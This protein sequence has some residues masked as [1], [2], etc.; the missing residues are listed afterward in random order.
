MT[1]VEALKELA[2]KIKGVAPDTLTEETISEVIKVISDNYS[3]NKEAHEALVA[4]VEK[5]LYKPTSNGTDGQVLKTLGNGQ[6]EW[7]N[8][9][10]SEKIEK[11]TTT[12]NLGNAPEAWAKA[13][14][15]KIRER[16]NVISGKIDELITAVTTAGLMKS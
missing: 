12:A 9:P 13:E 7:V 14:E 11:I 6:T 16:I 5:K 10:K 2:G 8:L 4:E 15:Q 3:G 1:I